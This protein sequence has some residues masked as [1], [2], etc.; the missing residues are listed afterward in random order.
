MGVNQSIECP[1]T[2]DK[3]IPDTPAEGLAPAPPCCPPGSEPLRAPPANYEDKGQT[4]VQHEMNVYSSLP[5]ES[6]HSEEKMEEPKEKKK[7]GVL[8]IQDAFGFYTGLHKYFAD[9]VASLGYIAVMPD[10]YHGNA[11]FSQG[12]FGMMFTAPAGIYKLRNKFNYNGVKGDIEK[13]MET[14]EK[15]HGIQGWI[16]AGFCWGGYI[17]AYLAGTGK[18][19]CVASAHPSL[20]LFGLCGENM[21]SVI[22]EIKC[23]LLFLPAGN[24]P[25]HAK[26]GG[27]VETTLIETNNPHL[28]ECVFH[29]FPEMSHG[30]TNR[31]DMAK[32]AVLRDAQKALA[33]FIEFAKKHAP[34]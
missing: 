34:Q 5:P 25:N 15:D 6:V 31:G 17:G 11:P 14:A 1:T 27:P 24:D 32:P 3:K 8:I 2:E 7:I 4:V 19:K 21:E 16:A 26:P 29:E 10:L 30:W 18:F 20:M 13:I 12:F 22:R 33:M 9:E 28:S 23:P